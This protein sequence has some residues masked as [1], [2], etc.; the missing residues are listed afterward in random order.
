VK[1]DPDPGFVAALDSVRDV[2]GWMTEDQARR[3]WDHARALQPPARVVEIGSYRGRSAIVL[4]KAAP[5]GVEIVAI[6]PHAGTDRG[7]QQIVGTVDEGQS[8]YERFHANLRNAGVEDRIR[9]VRRFSQ[10]ALDAIDGE[11]DL[12]YIDGAH[13]YRPARD[14]I[15]LW[16]KRVRDGGTMLIHDSFSSV[17]VTLA[18]IRA[19]FLTSRFRYVGRS[20]SMT[21]YQRASVRGLRRVSNALRQAAQLP[22]FAR[23]LGV[24]VALVTHLRPLARLL[25]HRTD[26]FP[27]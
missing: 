22:W 6:D 16:G 12:L 9:H 15:V 3:L 18:Q 27:Y 7:P 4:A 1:H 19:L 26:T 13:R 11:V 23:N 8:D 2:D 24:K 25:G 10:E 21:E 14:D 5:R 20:Q 17:G